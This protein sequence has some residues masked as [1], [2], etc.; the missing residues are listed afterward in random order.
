[1]LG[2][3]VDDGPT[4]GEVHFSEHAPSILATEHWSLLSARSLAYT[5]SFSRVT[6]FLTVLSASIVG[7]AL[8]ANTTGVGDEFTWAAGLLTPLVLFLGVT[9]YMRLVQLNLD[10]IFTVAAMN[11]I[12]NA[13]L[14][15]APELQP[16]FTTGWHDDVRGVMKSL[17]LVRSKA[18]D[19]K[20][21]FFITTPSVVALVDA[22]VAGA[23]VGLL[24][25]RTGTPTTG[26]I[27]LSSAVFVVVAFLL[28]RVQFAT[29]KEIAAVKPRFPST[30]SDY[31]D[32]L[33][34]LREG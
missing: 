5:E 8:V 32:E 1:M 34:P 25:S 9:T 10:D 18:A 31:S 13:Y 17:L 29:L 14:Q 23:A 7:L 19:P 4:S 20:I 30:P 28:L 33:G 21:Q 11:R 24:L 26:V 16:Y 3:M 22:F 12:R 6:V 27:G 2:F 15:M